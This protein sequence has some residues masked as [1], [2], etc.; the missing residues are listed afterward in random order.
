MKL[1]IIVVALVAAILAA[2]M[3][4]NV[5]TP[6]K[7]PEPV[8]VLSAAPAPAEPQVEKVNI[9]TATKDIAI[10]TEIQRTDYDFTPWPKHLL[11]P[12]ALVQGDPNTP[13]I[14][15]MMTSTPMVAGEPILITKLRNPSD[16]GF[17][18]G[19]LGEGMRAITIST[20]LTNSVA[21]FV[22]PGDS[23]DVLFTFDLS[24]AAIEGSDVTDIKGSD[25]NSGEISLSEVL[26]PNVKIIAV[27]SRVTAAPVVPEGGQAAPA[28]NLIPASVTLEVNQRDAQKLKL[29]EKIG[30]LTLVLRSVKD[31]AGY[32][33]VRPTAEQDLTRV[34]PPAYF[35]V[36]FDSDAAYDFGVVDLYGSTLSQAKGSGVM[37]VDPNTGKLIKKGGSAAVVKG[38][39]KEESIKT[40]KADPYTSIN[41]YRGAQLEK[42]EVNR[43]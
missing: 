40:E 42:V 24:K 36:L 16:P 11:P 5:V 6:E 23:V 37:S 17:I 43:Q 27:D 26:L 30:D 3:F 10:G 31:K 1:V 13:V 14:D 29:A 20:S 22:A 39:A 4:G 38:P 33:I 12:G 2:Y 35:P 8:A 7:P 9:Y 28:G 32:D 25:K 19:Q 41:V 18:A 34:L 15:K 21:G